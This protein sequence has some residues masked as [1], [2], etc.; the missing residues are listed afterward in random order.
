[1][2]GIDE[3]GAA[4]GLLSGGND[5]QGKRGLAGALRTENLSDAAAGQAANAHSGV[6]GDGAGRD[7]LVVGVAGVLACTTRKSMMCQ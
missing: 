3:G 2:L 1:M 5:V 7:D 4:A 6:K